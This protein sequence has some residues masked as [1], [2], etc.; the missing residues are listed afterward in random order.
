MRLA[1]VPLLLVL[2]GCASQGLP[3]DAFEPPERCAVEDD[4]CFL[5]VAHAFVV[6]VMGERYAARHVSEPNLTREPA[7]DF[8]LADPSSCAYQVELVHVVYRFRAPDAPWAD[9][10]AELVITTDDSRVHDAS[11]LPYCRTAPGECAFP[12]DED[13]A[14]GRAR[15]AGLGAGLSPW[16]TSFHFYHGDTRPMRTYVWSIQNTTARHAGG[17]EGDVV[18]LDAN[19][20]KILVRNSWTLIVD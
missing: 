6:H 13:A 20:G 18:L 2:S 19:T 14:I 1:A 9:E 10:L 8:C 5:R 4:A 3:D 17:A 11:G 7:H 16:E 12:I 15:R